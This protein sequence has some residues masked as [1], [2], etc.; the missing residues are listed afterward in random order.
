M[1][2]ESRTMT[3]LGLDSVY[4]RLSGQACWFGS[5]WLLT[6]FGVHMHVSHG[7]HEISV[8]DLGDL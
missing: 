4:Y 6:S 7:L 5:E 8:R 1:A 3:R 2:L